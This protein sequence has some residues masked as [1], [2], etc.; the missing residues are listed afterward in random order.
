MTKAPNSEVISIR[1]L[2][3]GYDGHPVLEDINLSVSER[4]FIGLIGPNGAGKTTLFLVLLGLLSP[5]SGEVRIL[6]ESPKKVRHQIG[7]V[8]QVVE[9]D[10]EFPIR[11][12]D[13]VQMGRLGVRR[14][15]QRFSGR[16]QNIIEE[17]PILQTSFRFTHSV[18]QQGLLES[19]SGT[20]RARL[21][22]QVV[23]ML[24]EQY[25]DD[26]H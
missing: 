4:D 17:S 12:W 20:K 23:H 14:L 6:G 7:Y 5:T 1:N 22:A 9:F 26:A 16:D 25:G 15:L 10:S 24:E 2:S 11:V 3:A 19:L 13:V 18:V 8:P 21:H